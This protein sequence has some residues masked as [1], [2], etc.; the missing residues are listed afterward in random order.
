M[1]RKTN[2]LV[3]SIVWFANSA[4]QQKTLD[5]SLD[6]KFNPWLLEEDLGH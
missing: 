1:K 4:I 2:R 6:P 5:L 3:R